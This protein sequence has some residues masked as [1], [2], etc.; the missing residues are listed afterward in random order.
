MF[1]DWWGSTN[2]STYFRSWNIIIQDWLFEY[3]YRDFYQYIIP[4]NKAAAKW[5][6]FLLSAAIHEQVILFSTGHFVPILFIQF[7]SG[8]VFSS[9]RTKHPV[10]NIFMLY[11]LALGNTIQIS[12]HVIEYYARRN[13]PYSTADNSTSFVPRFITLDCV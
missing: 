12:L 13:C 10:Y 6:V 4:Q 8:A 11:S 5:V 7:L 3:V 2:Y 1:Q 9:L